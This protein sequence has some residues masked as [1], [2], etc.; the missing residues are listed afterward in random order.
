MK[1]PLA[2]ALAILLVLAS[3]D[4]AIAPDVLLPSPTLKAA[5]L[6]D[7][8]EHP[9]RRFDVIFFIALPF[10]ILFT[11]LVPG[12]LGLGTGLRAGIVEKSSVKASEFPWASLYLRSDILFIGINS[13][14]WSASIAI[15]DF[16]EGRD[17]LAG[18]RLR[19]AMDD[20]RIDLT[21]LRMAF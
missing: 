7:G 6:P 1:R 15:N 14:L 17:P 4:A 10:T 12:L 11:S 2:R 5:V 20:S 3:L 19:R 18:D 13:V 21:L 9:A 16:Q 8:G